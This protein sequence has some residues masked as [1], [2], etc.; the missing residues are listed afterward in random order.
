VRAR[1]AIGFAGRFLVAA[2]VLL[3]L[4]VVY[5]LWG[6]GILEARH[7]A[8][9]RQE[10]EVELH[11]A[12][13]AA[14]KPTAAHS[15]PPVD[16]RPAAFALPPPEGQ[17]VGVLQIPKINV[18]VVV[19]EGTATSDLSLG[20]GLYPGAPL[21][22]QVGNAAIAG[23]RTTYGAPFYSLNQLHDGDSID[24]T[25]LQG[26]FR[27]LVT[28]SEVVNPSDVGVVAATPFAELTLTTCDPP[29]SAANR[30][31]VHA[32]LVGRVAPSPPPPARGRSGGSGGSRVTMPVAQEAGLAGSAGSW[33]GALW[34]GLGIAG[35]GAAVWLVARRSRR[36]WVVY[37]ASTPL[38]V[39][40]L[41]FFFEGI[42]GIVPASF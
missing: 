9:L 23:H 33:L 35:L 13:A 15:P 39:V 11:Q 16:P 41:F 36:H 17:P 30:L 12:H 10:F 42:S 18:D 38:F 20:P 27:F 8:G 31:I 28:G 24:V 14:A 37:L 40:P 22:G 2:G 5:Q 7:Q 25:T 26:S 6:T 21:P 32:R 19:V 34:W 1:R 29:F 3:L 4:F